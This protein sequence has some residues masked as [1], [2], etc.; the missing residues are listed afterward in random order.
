MNQTGSILFKLN[1]TCLSPAYHKPPSYCKSL[2]FSSSSPATVITPNQFHWGADITC[3]ACLR[4]W[5][6]VQSFQL[7]PAGQPTYLFSAQSG[8]DTLR[9]SWLLAQAGNA[10]LLTGG[11]EAKSHI[12]PLSRTDCQH[13]SHW[14]KTKGIILWEMCYTD[15]HQVFL[16]ALWIQQ[17]R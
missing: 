1:H 15:P 10:H 9:H 12:Q 3:P 14:E 2:A 11:F 17:L 5:K 6:A 16:G 13:H 4:S 7:Q 8:V